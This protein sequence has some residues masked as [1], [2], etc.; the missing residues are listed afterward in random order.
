M[1]FHNW[2]SIV[3]IGFVATL[4]HGY[5]CTL[6]DPPHAENVEVIPGTI[7]TVDEHSACVHN[8]EMNLCS[9]SPDLKVYYDRSVISTEIALLDLSF[10]LSSSA[11]SETRVLLKITDRSRSSRVSRDGKYWSTVLKPDKVVHF[12]VSPD[13]NLTPSSRQLI[14]TFSLLL[15]FPPLSS[16]SSSCQALTVTVDPLPSPVLHEEDWKQLQSVFKICGTATPPSQ[17]SVCSLGWCDFFREGR[18]RVLPL[19]NLN[20]N[21]DITEFTSRFPGLEHLDLSGNSISGALILDDHNTQWWESIRDLRLHGC[22]LQAVKG[23]APV[24]QYMDLSANELEIFQI[25]FHR[26]EKKSQLLG[27]NLSHNLKLQDFDL[28]QLPDSLRELHV[29]NLGS[30]LK[31]DWG[32]LPRELVFLD[33]SDNPGALSD[34][35]IDGTR[36]PNL[37]HLVLAFSP[38]IR[39]VDFLSLAGL[40]HVDLI[41]A[42]LHQNVRLWDL[43]CLNTNLN[44]LGNHIQLDWS[45]FEEDE[46]SI[47]PFTSLNTFKDLRYNNITIV[48]LPFKLPQTILLFPQRDYTTKQKHDNRNT[49]QSSNLRNCTVYSNPSNNNTVVVDRFSDVGSAFMAATIIL[50]LILGVTL[51]ISSVRL[52]NHKERHR[53]YTRNTP[54]VE[55]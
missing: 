16:S 50:S 12:K 30:G 37:A 11:S 5:N 27:L 4:S 35:K 42:D 34:V 20:F 23:S 29:I 10:T 31:V 47:C 3:Y 8:L 45:T 6:F 52:R 14:F 15:P 21:C 49:T 44:L 39:T 25:T 40:L 48:E 46:P 18:L 33:L 53:G 13:P 24:I 43:L 19:A 7:L 26:P 54:G 1:N 32:K 9:N 22:S 17:Q 28:S 2:F 51:C 38:P 41:H 55:S 36:T